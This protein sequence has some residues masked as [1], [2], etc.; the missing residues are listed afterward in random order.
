M[1][2][3]FNELSVPLMRDL[4][5]LD[6]LIEKYAQ[7]IKEAKLQGFNM[8]RY[9][10]GV[11]SIMLSDEY[12]LSQYLYDHQAL[13]SVN[14]LLTTQAKPYIPDGDVAEESYILNDYSVELN[15]RQVISEENMFAFY[16]LGD[17]KDKGVEL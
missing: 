15:G 9:E 1:D 11:G 7:V 13:P 4:N 12:S 8:V 10:N 14:I 17:L 2:V 5:N 3:F 6:I 16:H